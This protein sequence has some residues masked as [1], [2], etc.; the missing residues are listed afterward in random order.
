MTKGSACSSQGANLQ[1]S[2]PRH[3]PQAVFS[4]LRTL[5]IIGSGAF[6]RVALVEMDGIVY[7]LKKMRRGHLAAKGM[8][9]QILRERC[10]STVFTM[11][12][13]IALGFTLFA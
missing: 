13:C 1:L 2:K 12:T 3:R 6:G 11:A 10:G 9:P 4:E 7:V 8:K 5:A